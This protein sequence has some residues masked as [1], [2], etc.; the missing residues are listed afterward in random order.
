M[1]TT[2]A[3]SEKELIDEIEKK[4]SEFQMALTNQSAAMLEQSKKFDQFIVAILAHLDGSSTSSKSD[5]QQVGD[6][7]MADAR[8]L[9]T[10]FAEFFTSSPSLGGALAG[11]LVPPLPG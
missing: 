5:S 11:A 8:E 7:F 9:H 1:A 4:L 2:R 6:A 3:K 10:T